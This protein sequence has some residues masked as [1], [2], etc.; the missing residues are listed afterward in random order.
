MTR[1]LAVDLG[2]RKTGIAWCG[3]GGMVE[4]LEVVETA[5]LE[6]ALRRWIRELE[7]DSLVYGLPL[8]AGKLAGAAKKVRREARAMAAALELPVEFVDESG[9]TDEAMQRPGSKGLDARAAGL[10]LERYLV[11]GPWL[12]ERTRNR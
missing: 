3:P 6:A 9:T 8:R 2:E 10:I 12:P 1:L 11:Q 4:P 5:G 7:I